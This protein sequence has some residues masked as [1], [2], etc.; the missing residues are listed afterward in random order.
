MMTKRYLSLGSNIGNKEK[1]IHKAI[2]L[3]KY[4]N[5]LRITK[6]SSLYKTEPVLYEQQDWFINCAVEVE[7]PLDLGGLFKL[8]LD[9]EK[10][11]GKDVKIR[12]GP[13]IID[14]DIL[15]FGN[16][17]KNAEFE[18]DKEKY[19]VQVPHPRL[20]TRKF[21]LLPLNEIAPG[22]MHPIIKK[23]ISELLSDLDS[24]NAAKKVELW[25]K[26]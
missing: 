15:L 26:S 18:I 22:L 19:L 7:T 24:Q 21:V 3:L 20:H 6:V 9:V 1:N 23:T 16:E 4:K 14:I 17:I 11:L 8:T 5:I 2:E 10:K 25:K 12:F 13:R